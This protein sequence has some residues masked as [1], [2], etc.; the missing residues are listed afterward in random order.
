MRTGILLVF[1]GVV[2]QAASPYLPEPGRLTVSATYAFDL[3]SRYHAG[4]QSTALPGTLYQHSVL[5]QLSY[6][7]SRRVALDFDTA[8]TRATVPGNT[9][10]A[11]V[12]TGYGVRVQLW[13]KE[14]VTLAA[15]VGG[16]RSEFYPI[17]LARDVPGV[18]VNGFLG[19]ALVGVRLPRQTFVLLDAGYARYGTPT[20]GRFL[21]NVVI[22]QRRGHW[23]CFAGY[24]DHRAVS[25][26]DIPNA[27]RARE[28]YA[29]YRRVFGGL[30]LGAGYTTRG[31]TYFGLT[32]NR[33]LH[34]RNAGE[35]NSVAFTWAWAVPK[36]GPHF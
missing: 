11:P 15:R 12:N 1:C 7:L 25:G 31:G 2:A 20:P 35:S 18:I 5:P 3:Y 23:T 29:E 28:R 34:A 33:W 26:V 16:I 4:R 32:Y 21:G 9:V 17:D 24:Q 8:F 6:G 14:R 10:Q 22:G 30:D 27:A 13:R 36:K 19:S